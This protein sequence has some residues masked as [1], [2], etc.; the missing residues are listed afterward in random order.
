MIV[1]PVYEGVDLLGV[2]RPFEMFH[3]ANI[4]VRVVARVAG[5]ITCNG[6]L[7]LQVDTG[8]ADA[9]AAEVLWTPGGEGRQ[10]RRSVSS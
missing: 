9:P 4:E 2:T 8:F 3:W 1:I 10:G 7:T 6:G 5:P